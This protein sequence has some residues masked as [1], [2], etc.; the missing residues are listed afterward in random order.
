M[1]R[2]DKYHIKHE[3]GAIYLT[4]DDKRFL[5]LDKAIKHQKALLNKIK[6]RKGG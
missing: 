1:A 4:K 5:S 2:L 3:L 6:S